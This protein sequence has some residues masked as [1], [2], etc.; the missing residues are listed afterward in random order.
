MPQKILLNSYQAKSD[1]NTRGLYALNTEDYKDIQN[2]IISRIENPYYYHVIPDTKN[3]LYYRV[4]KAGIKY[5]LGNNE[6]GK[7]ADKP[8]Y[9]QI[10]DADFNT[11]KE[12]ELPKNTY[13]ALSSFINEEGEL[14]IPKTHYL[15][16]NLKE[17]KLIF[18]KFIFNLK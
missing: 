10:L 11:I 15:Y 13:D 14:L 2:R 18:D 4:H 16:P 12:I 9:I 17:D 3:N 6:F 1:L 5:D 8:V 7:G